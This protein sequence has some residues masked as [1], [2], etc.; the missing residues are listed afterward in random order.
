MQSRK[1]Y[2]V[3]HGLTDGNKD[4]FYYGRTDL[5][6]NREG[7]IQSYRTAERLSPVKR[8]A[9]YSSGLARAAETSKIIAQGRGLEAIRDDALIEMDFGEYEGKRSDD[10][11]GTEFQKKW[12]ETPAALK[13]PGGESLSEVQKRIQ[14]F[15]DRIE[16]THSGDICVVSHAFA[17]IAYLCGLAGIDLNRFRVVKIDHASITVIEK[18]PY[19]KR[20]LSLN[21]TFHLV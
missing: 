9:V 12:F 10:F 14:G 19:V 16:N 7:V 11:A 3:R 17:I 15:F 13:W 21:E 20:I 1:I 18:L 8:E 2:L 5:P 6:L 4:G